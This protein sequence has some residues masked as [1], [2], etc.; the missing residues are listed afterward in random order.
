MIGAL[1]GYVRFKDAEER[2]AIN[3]MVLADGHKSFSTWARWRLG[4]VKI[5]DARKKPRPRDRRQ[6]KIK[7]VA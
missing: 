4:L 6:L 1:I 3:A 2:D 7:D 5:E